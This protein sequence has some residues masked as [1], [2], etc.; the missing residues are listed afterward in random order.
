MYTHVHMDLSVDRQ[1]DSFYEAQISQRCGPKYLIDLRT[2][3]D[4]V[5]NLHKNYD[6]IVNRLIF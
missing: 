5:Q 1:T 6:I 2:K 3:A 4:M